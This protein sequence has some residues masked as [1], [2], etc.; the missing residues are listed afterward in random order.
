MSIDA[1]K[2]KIRRLKNPSALTIAPT[3]E[4]VPPMIASAFEDPVQA[5]GEYCLRVLNAMKGQLPAVKVSFSAFALHGPEGLTQLKEVLNTANKLGFYTILDW[6]HQEDEVAAKAAA[7]LLLT[8]DAWKCDAVVL[9]AYA[10]SGTVKPYIAAA[11][12]EKKDVYVV[13]KTGGKSGSEL[14]DLQTGGRMVYTAGADLLTKWGD[15]Y[16]ERCGYSRVAA[17][18]AANHMSSIRNLRT[19]YP[20]L[21]LLVDGLEATNANAKNASYAFDKMGYGALVCAN[22]LTAWLENPEND[23]I[24]EVTNAA[25][26][27]KRNI[28]TYVTIL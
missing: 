7:K 28:T 10:G 27:M 18:C 15:P 16:V 21:F 4:M 17:V 25:Q 3:P 20:K 2:N 24:E 13:L 8:G 22:L 1:L 14:Q 6:Q 19:K 5:M 26:R 12:G 23:P 11:E 9:S